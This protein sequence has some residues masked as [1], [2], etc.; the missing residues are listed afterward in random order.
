MHFMDLG[1]DFLHVI[2]KPKFGYGKNLNPCI[3]CRTYLLS[4][5]KKLMERIGAS[6]LVTGEVL[7]QRPKSQHE[8][9]FN[10]AEREAG[11]RGMILRPL[12]AHRLP[13]TTPELEGWVDRKKLLGIAGRGRNEQMELAARW[14]LS[15]PS[16]AGGCLLTM[17]DYSHRMRELM[18]DRGGLALNDVRLL[19]FGR[20]FRLGPGVKAITGRDRHENLALMWAYRRDPQN[21]VLMKVEGP[22]GPLTLVSGSSTPGQLRIAASITARYADVTPDAPVRVK[23]LARRGEKMI[24]DDVLPFS[25]AEVDRHRV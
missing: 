19:R 13:P 17:E 15:Y 7:G 16:P 1:A 6:F 8:S 25:A 4:E 14:G 18:N 10:I 12:S 9:A 2:E 11:L 21:A 3:D 24:I 23:A 5:A 22:P 20:H